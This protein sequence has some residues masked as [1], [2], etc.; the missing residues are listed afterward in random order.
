MVV[1]MEKLENSRVK[2]TVDIDGG[3]LEKA[4]DEAYRKNV[5]KINIPGFRKGKAPR[6][7]IELNYGPDVFLE[8]AVDI[9]L[10][11]LYEEALRETEIH[12]VDQPDADI[13][14]IDRSE[15]ATFTFTVDVYPELELGNYKGLA[16]ERELVQVTDEDVDSIL[17]QQQERSSE[18]IVVDRTTVQD[19]DF[20]VIDYIGYV[21]GQPFSGGA[22]ENQTLEIG[23]GRFIPGFEEQLIGL[24]VG[25][26]K[27]IQVTFP[28]E[29]HAEQ[30]AGKEATFTVTVKELKEKSLPELDDEFAKD[31]SEHETLEELK[32][33][34]RK[35][36]EDEATRR[37]TEQMENRLLELIAEDSP[38]E[39]PESMIRHQAEHLLEYF[40]ERLKGQGLNEETYLQMTGQ[41]REKLL[42][43]FEP[44]AKTQILHDLILEAINER[45]GNT[46]SEEE[47]NDKIQEYISSTG[48]LTPEL[49]ATMREYWN[50]QRR[51]LEMSILRD[52]AIKVIVDSTQITDVEA[53]QGTSEE[54]PKK[55]E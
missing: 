49:E 42:S 7:I 27:D 41:T 43:E 28:T 51:G 35:N 46:A 6:R 23:S 33:E 20:T 8:D 36:L 32:A 11:R 48:E 39:I 10:P 16:V 54:G 17:K 34:I 9:L 38:V 47:V 52:K 19:G 29:Y 40:F 5:K 26:T 13:E 45:E 18:L 30:L 37:T 31:I 4:M 2:L 14:K 15:G 55:A 1:K 12:P 44:Q 21:D 53:I 50:S 25:E 22:G 24:E 3:V